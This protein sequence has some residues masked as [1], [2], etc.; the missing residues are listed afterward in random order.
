V[1]GYDIRNETEGASEI[2][3]TVRANFS[4]FRHRGFFFQMESSSSRFADNLIKD[5]TRTKVITRALSEYG[6]QSGQLIKKLKNPAYMQ[7]PA[8]FSPDCT[9][10]AL[11]GSSCSAA[12][13]N[14]ES[15][16]MER[17]STPERVTTRE[18]SPSLGSR[19]RPRF[20]DRIQ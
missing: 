17:L 20:T 5:I 19:G 6:T 18:N 9:L 16:D 8:A 11:F 2:T 4:F 12:L 3:V 7:D 1:W 13:W 10:L 15:G 14:L